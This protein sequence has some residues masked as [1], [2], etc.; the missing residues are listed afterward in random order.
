MGNDFQFIG[1]DNI[2]LQ[3][4]AYQIGRLSEDLREILIVDDAKKRIRE[5]IQNPDN[6]RI[7][8]PARVQGIWNDVRKMED[9]PG[10]R[11]YLTN[12]SRFIDK[13][14]RAKDSWE[15]LAQYI[16]Q[17]EV[18]PDAQSQ[19]EI[20]QTEEAKL[21]PSHDNSTGGGSDAG[22]KHSNPVA[23]EASIT[24]AEAL[25]LHGFG[26]P[27]CP[28]KGLSLADVLAMSEDSHPNMQIEPESLV[29]LLRELAEKLSGIGQRSEARRLVTEFFHKDFIK[30]A[31]GH[32]RMG[33][34]RQDIMNA[35]TT[36]DV[37][38]AVESLAAQ[39]EKE[40][41][42]VPT[43]EANVQNAVMNRWKKNEVE[44]ETWF[45]RD[46]AF[47]GIQVRETGDYIAEWWDEDVSAAFEDGFFKSGRDFDKSVIEYADHLGAEA[48][49]EY[50]DAKKESYMLNVGYSFEST[51]D[52]QFLGAMVPFGAMATAESV[53]RQG[54][55]VEVVSGVYTG[56]RGK[57]KKIGKVVE[58]EL[59]EPWSGRVN[60]I[61]MEIP[62]GEVIGLP[63]ADVDEKRG[64][65]SLLQDATTREVDW[66]EAEDEINGFLRM[67]TRSVFN[68]QEYMDIVNKKLAQFDLEVTGLKS[69][70]PEGEESLK[71]LY[72]GSVMEDAKLDLKW[73]TKGNRTIV[74]A[75]IF[76]PESEEQKQEQELD[77]KIMDEMETQIERLANAQAAEAW[78]TPSDDM[79]DKF[80]EDVW[81]R[82]DFGDA[83]A[84][85]G[86]LIRDDET[87]KPPEGFDLTNE[88]GDIP[89]TEEHVELRF[90]RDAVAS[91]LGISDDRVDDATYK[92]YKGQFAVT[93]ASGD[94]EIWARPKEEPEEEPAT[95]EAD[96]VTAPK[97]DPKTKKEVNEYL[98]ELS[99]QY[100]KSIPLA[101]IRANL[102]ASGLDIEDVILTG[103]D[104]RDTFDL[105][106]GGQTVSNSVLILSWHKME[107]SGNWEINAYLS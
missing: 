10:I 38:R 60:N 11:S 96:K 69:Q 56:L 93:S 24:P 12:V 19:E 17:V 37:K 36:E 30:K 89:T 77:D 39:V 103:R 72:N 46:R 31:L 86:D 88:G 45:E 84:V 4:I 20:P 9:M 32:T 66:V 1:K 43:E 61:V 100:H 83:T 52:E 97:I 74:M 80:G 71:V 101:D 50:K 25:I 68:L 34:V 82:A 14:D 92:Q 13:E 41:L 33:W 87:A 49:P 2:S 28:Q 51:K 6:A 67:Q 54:Q 5:I 29:K 44:V 91:A 48:Y 16:G 63:H 58:V 7:L 27:S 73:Y 18:P 42:P 90:V 40:G 22:S 35:T 47:V 106:M 59:T 85:N 21:C 65:S 94:S 26:N 55:D 8:G 78:S 53:V 57:I 79:I 95:N 105:T 15:N 102:Q 23:Q 64:S 3:D 81:V 98:Y 104:G 62:A 76:I 99:R 75:E 107:P 70:E